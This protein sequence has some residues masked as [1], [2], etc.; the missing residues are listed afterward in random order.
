MLPGTQQAHVAYQKCIEN[1][2]AHCD[3]YL[4]LG[5]ML[6]EEGRH[7]E[8]CAL[9]QKAIDH[10]PENPQLH[11]NLGVALEDMTVRK[12]DEVLRSEIDR[13]LTQLYGELKSIAAIPGDAG[14]RANP[15]SNIY[16]PRRN[17]WKTYRPNDA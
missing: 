10:C 12:G 11:Y 9:Y 5:H 1:D 8:V 14:D 2:V 15:C 4:N 13:A 7:A 16:P 6:Q 17:L 3:A